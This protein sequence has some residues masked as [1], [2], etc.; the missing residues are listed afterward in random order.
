MTMNFLHPCIADIDRLYV[1]KKT[2]G[3]GMVYVYQTVKEAKRALE[4]Y[5]ITVKKLY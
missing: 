1:S 3:Y 4:E 2:G 5:L